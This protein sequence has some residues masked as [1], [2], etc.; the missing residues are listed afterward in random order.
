MSKKANSLEGLAASNVPPGSPMNKRMRDRNDP[1]ASATPSDE[2]MNAL[3]EQVTVSTGTAAA[4]LPR[5]TWRP[6]AHV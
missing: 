1:T 5:G 4:G 6:G 2:V 3:F